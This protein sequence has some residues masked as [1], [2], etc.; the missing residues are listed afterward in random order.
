MVKVPKFHWKFLRNFLQIVFFLIF[1]FVG[2]VLIEMP[3]AGWRCKN[4]LPR[5]KTY[6]VD[7]IW[8]KILSDPHRIDD[9]IF[10]LCRKIRFKVPSSNLSVGSAWNDELSARRDVEGDPLIGVDL[11]MKDSVQRSWKVITTDEEFRCEKNLIF[12]TLIA[13]RNFN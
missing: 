13:K 5:M 3:L 11:A 10:E 8:M 9:R 2:I 12:Y 6:S 1:T 7:A 4:R